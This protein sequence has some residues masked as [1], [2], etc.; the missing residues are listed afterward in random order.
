MTAESW[1]PARGRGWV[2]IL[3][4]GFEH[5]ILPEIPPA[6]SEGLGELEDLILPHEHLQARPV[7]HTPS[8]P[9]PRHFWGGLW[10]GQSGRE[11]LG[12]SEKAKVL[13]WRVQRGA[14]PEKRGSGASHALQ[15]HPGT[16]FWVWVL[17]RSQVTCRKTGRAN[18]E[19]AVG[20]RQDWWSLL[21]RPGPPLNGQQGGL[22]LAAEP[23][24]TGAQVPSSLPAS[25]P[26][27]RK[28]LV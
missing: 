21:P 12:R 6:E 8:L 4:K 23:V 2:F 1:S 3:L 5:P 16:P 15:I 24:F 25:R 26:E 10:A 19:G 27:L 14:G 9:P 20:P 17:L 11:P 7:F 22:T 28:H 13:I 18:P